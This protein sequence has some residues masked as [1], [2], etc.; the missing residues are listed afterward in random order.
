[1][2][3]CTYCTRDGIVGRLHINHDMGGGENKT[4]HLVDVGQPVK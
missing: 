2:R 1:M 4:D 3:I